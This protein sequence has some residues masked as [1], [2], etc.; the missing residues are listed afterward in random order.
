MVPLV[1]Y[2]ADFP[3][4]AYTYLSSFVDYLSPQRLV[5]LTD[6]ARYLIS[7]DTN[8]LSSNW[9]QCVACGSILR[10]LQRMNWSIPQQCQNCLKEYCWDGT[11]DN[12][13]PEYLE[14][15][16]VR[17]TQTS[18]ADWNASFYERVGAHSFC[19]NQKIVGDE[20]SKY[21]YSGPRHASTVSAA[22]LLVSN[23][24]KRDL[25]LLRCYET[26]VLHPLDAVTR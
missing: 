4:S 18:W 21:L 13:P 1:L 24:R 25:K 7:Q 19:G 15:A 8:Q 23:G 14:P 12:S 26:A 10:S 2:A 6:N 22:H 3:Y 9:T 11:V 17:E 5:N 20:A 16:L